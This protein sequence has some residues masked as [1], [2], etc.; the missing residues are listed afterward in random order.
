MS[1]KDENLVEDIDNVEQI[2]EEELVDETQVESDEE[3]LEE[4]AKVKEEED[5]DEV[6]DESDEDEDEDEVEEVQIPKTK[7]GIVNAAY[8]M[9]KKPL[10]LKK[11]MYLTLTTKKILMYWL[12]KKLLCPKDSVTKLL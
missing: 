8:E 1:V 5:E 2:Q 12:L 7:A 6:E 11:L 4:K 9:L 10:L 3:T